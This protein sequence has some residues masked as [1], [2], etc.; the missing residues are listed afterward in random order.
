[1]R[2][3]YKRNTEKKSKRRIKIPVFIIVLALSICAIVMIA[4]ISKEE[5]TNIESS[6]TAKRSVSVLELVPDNYAATLHVMG[7]VVPEWQTAINSQVNALITSI[8]P[9]FRVGEIV[10][11]GEVLITCENIQY[12]ALV[13]EAKTRLS[14]AKINLLSTQ[15]EAEDALD[16][17]N[18]SGIE[19]EP[20]SSLVLYKPQLEAAQNEFKA[21]ETALQNAEL[22]LSYTKVMAP[23]NGIIV[24]RHVNLGEAIG[25]GTPVLKLF[26]TDKAIISVHISNHQYGLLPH[27]LTSIKARLIDDETKISWNAKVVRE[28]NRI[29]K[30][31]RLRPLFLEVDNPL[32][33]QNTLLAGQFL[34]VE[35]VGKEMENILKAPESV[36]T[37]GGFIWYV[38]RKNQ[39][40]SFPVN[41]H[42]YLNTELYFSMPEEVEAPIKIAINPNS[43]FM[44]GLAAH[45]ITVKG[46]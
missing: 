5:V 24:E 43:S 34:N 23:F 13:A 8:S 2:L 32:Q 25:V 19:G 40:Q 15:K 42:F 10:N 4:G 17:W 46:E 45:P 44:N 41:P 9:K 11:K 7:E 14:T 27:D 21:A 26:S 28:G 16:N 39:L 6:E 33:Q 30:D 20:S 31:S 29:D 36:L 3:F 1:M 12:L 37:E 22:E 35:L 18:R 38:N